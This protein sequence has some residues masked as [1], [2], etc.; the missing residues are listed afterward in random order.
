VALIDPDGNESSSMYPCFEHPTLTDELNAKNLSWR[1]YAPYAGSIWTGPNAI[2]HMC[3]PNATPPNA[4]ECVGSDWVNNVVLNPAQILTDISN[5]ELAA[6]T[7]V[8]PSGQNSDHPS[9]NTG[10]GPSWVASIVNAIGGSSYWGNTAI[11]ITWDDWGGWYD[12]LRRSSAMAQV[13]DR[14]ISMG[15]GC[16]SSWSRPMPNPDTSLIECMIS[17]AS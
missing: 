16:L 7:W 13:G 11:I 3:G 6:V 12:L 2:Q 14:V 5:N 1:Y 8:I 17:E 9:G 10:G 4:T 15:S